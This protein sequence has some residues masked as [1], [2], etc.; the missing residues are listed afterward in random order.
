MT[1]TKPSRPVFHPVSVGPVSLRLHRRSVAVGTI[2]LL[3]VL[4]VGFGALIQPGAGL[5]S[6]DALAVL[7]GG[8]DGFPATV[9]LQW[10]LSRIV[11]AIVIGGALALSGA[12]FQSLTRNPLGSPDV[13]GFNTGAYTGVLL[14]MYGGAT[15]FAPIAGASL[16]GGIVAAGAV[17]LLSQRSGSAGLRMVLVGLGVSAMLAAVNR[18]LIGAADLDLSMA[19]ATWGAGDLNGLRWIQVAP[20]GIALVVLVAGSVAL[21]RR[22]QALDL[23][24][25]A[26]AGL[27]L[28]L[29]VTR[30]L[31]L[32][33]AV[34]L[35]AVSTAI[36]GPISF[37]ALAAPHLAR[38]ITRSP[39][40]TPF[41][42]ALTGAALLLVADVLAQ[43]TFDPIQLPVGVVTTTIG[44]IYLVLLLAKEARKS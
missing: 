30:P 15:G 7:F 11:A 39:Q 16:A 35:T 9:V 21:T 37:V 33:V 17:Y 31:L 18:W 24:D 5:T 38:R 22:L 14:A 34:G 2:L 40:V 28:R 42:T 10:R 43:R 8:L 1:S 23:G 19:A 32:A 29:S 12:I 4:L 26:A 27:G 13:I 41:P 6:A 20:A 44:G 25:D 36:A 3:V